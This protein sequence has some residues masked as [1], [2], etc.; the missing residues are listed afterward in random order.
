MLKARILGP[1]VLVFVGLAALYV[2]G[3]Y[4]LH[5]HE[6]ESH[7]EDRMSRAREFYDFALE[8]DAARMSAALQVVQ[9]DTR[10]QSA[11]LGRDRGRLLELASPLF[12]AL[13]RDHRITHFY[14][15]EPNQVSSLRVHMPERHGD[16]IIRSTMEQAGAQVAVSENGELALETALAARE[17]GE[18]FDCILMDMQMPIMDGYE[19]TARLR[20]VDYTGPI[21]ALTAHATGHD[22]EKCIAAGCDDYATKPVNRKKLVEVIRANLRNAVSA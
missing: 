6:I 3:S 9:R 7:F 22:R 12:D 17:A 20:L 8:G 19:A 2:V 13:R 14:F 10:N 15:H 16:V 4:R 11:W 5:E 18:D 1:L 21:I